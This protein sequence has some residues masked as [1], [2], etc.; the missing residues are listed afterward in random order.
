MTWGSISLHILSGESVHSS[1]EDS[2]L[3]MDWSSNDIDLSPEVEVDDSSISEDT[4][5]ASSEGE[6]IETGVGVRVVELSDCCARFI[7][8]P[9]VN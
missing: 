6:G 9:A 2:E 7:A 1:G 3:A 4:A 8:K 5:D